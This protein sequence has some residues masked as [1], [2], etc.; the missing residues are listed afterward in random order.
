MFQLGPCEF[1][2]LG[3]TLP[4]YN[5]GRIESGFPLV[6]NIT[7][8]FGLREVTEAL[9]AAGATNPQHNGIDIA[10]DGGA[11]GCP[12]V[13]PENGIVTRADDDIDEPD[14]PYRGYWIEIEALDGQFR[15]GTYHLA[16]PARDYATGVDLKVGDLVRRG[17]A[18]GMVGTTGASTGIH[19]HTYVQQ[20][21]ADATPEGFSWIF[22]DPVP[23]FVLRP[24]AVPAAFPPLERNTLGR[25]LLSGR[26]LYVNEG[27]WDAYTEIYRLLVQRDA[28]TG[29]VL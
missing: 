7:S 17:Q 12:W 15:Y 10:P 20:K 23:F 13:N 24:I 2:P 29:E 28:V 9:R 11:S 25:A 16:E 4:G 8:P 14:G 3:N 1:N 5:Y 21:I 19:S 18:V 6:G 26:G 22:V 27:A